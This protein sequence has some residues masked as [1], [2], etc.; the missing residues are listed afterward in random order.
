MAPLDLLKPKV[1]TLEDWSPDTP[2]ARIDMNALLADQRPS[3]VTALDS[4]LSECLDSDHLPFQVDYLFVSRIARELPETCLAWLEGK[5]PRLAST[6]QW[7]LFER[8][9]CLA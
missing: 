8:R 7:S 3:S 4:F 5:Y 1:R 6:K 2:R 9:P